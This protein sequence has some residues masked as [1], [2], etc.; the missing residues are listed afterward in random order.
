MLTNAKQ[1]VCSASCNLAMIAEDE[2]NRGSDDDSSMTDLFQADTMSTGNYADPDL[3]N[4]VAPG[5]TSSIANNNVTFAEQ[6][7]GE[8]NRSTA[9]CAY[10]GR[11]PTPYTVYSNNNLYIPPTTNV[12]VNV[13]SRFV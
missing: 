13:N 11:R 12:N 1:S 6:I 9:R 4:Y 5:N 7:C 3:E 8:T 2:I 10:F